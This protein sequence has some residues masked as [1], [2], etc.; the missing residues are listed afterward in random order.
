MPY[1]TFEKLRVLQK[2]SSPEN[3]KYSVFALTCEGGRIYRNTFREVL[4]ENVQALM[5]FLP[6][7]EGQ[8]WGNFVNVVYCEKG[9]TT[10]WMSQRA[11]LNVVHRSVTDTDCF[12]GYVTRAIGGS[13]NQ[14]FAVS[15][16]DFK[17]RPCFPKYNWE[18]LDTA[19]HTFIFTPTGLCFCDASST[20]RWLAPV[21]LRRS[22]SIWGGICK[23]EGGLCDVC[24]APDSCRYDEMEPEE[25][26]LVAA[27][28]S[29]SRLFACDA[30]G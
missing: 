14:F 5:R 7:A 9:E 6:G 16:I 8:I 27:G 23:G 15:V 24:H 1:C 12:T 28:C 29:T 20:T 26:W 22:D 25:A 11:D 4:C 13:Y 30:E 2:G 3:H 18:I 10:Y 21:F 19:G 17:Q